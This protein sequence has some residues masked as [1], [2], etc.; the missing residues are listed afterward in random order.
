MVDKKMGKEYREFLGVKDEKNRHIGFRI[1]DYF[2]YVVLAVLLIAINVEWNLLQNQTQQLAAFFIVAGIY[3]GA[4]TIQG[5]MDGKKRL[6]LLF[7]IPA[8]LAFLLAF[9]IL[10]VG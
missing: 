1:L 10:A 2:C 3:S 6:L 9:F 4:H 7:G 8:L 5:L